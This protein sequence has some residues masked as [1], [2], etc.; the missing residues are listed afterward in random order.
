[1]RLDV[2]KE[3]EVKMEKTIEAY[4]E[5]LL[6][7][8]AGRANPTLLDK[9]MVECYGQPTPINQVANISAPEPRMLVVQPWDKTLISDIEKGILLS[10]LGLNPSNDGKIIRIAIPMLTEERRKE[11]IKVVKKNG[12]NAKVVIRNTRRDQNDAIKALEKNKEI[13]EDERKAAEDV[14]QEITDKYTKEVDRI[15]EA[16]EAELIEI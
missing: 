15:T 1:M 12:E 6:S 4:K 11:L 5:E 14:M 10:D 7:I 2:H 13:S 3:A 16:K 9:V 8:R